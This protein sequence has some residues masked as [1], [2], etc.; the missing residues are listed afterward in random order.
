MKKNTEIKNLGDEIKNISTQNKDIDE[1]VKNISK[2]VTDLQGDFK[3]A[4]PMV[5][6]KINCWLLSK[7]YVLP[8]IS[9]TGDC[10][11]DF[12]LFQFRVLHRFGH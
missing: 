12:L 7:C 6:E 5:G 9:I 8:L 10:L 4:Y 2:N 1:S 3:N 11:W